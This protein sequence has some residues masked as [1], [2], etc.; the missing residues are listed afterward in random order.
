MMDKMTWLTRV[1]A[2][3]RPTIDNVGGVQMTRRS[4]VY[5]LTCAGLTCR[6]GRFNG[7]IIEKLFNAAPPKR[8]APLGRFHVLMDPTNLTF[9]YVR[10]LVSG[11]YIFVPIANLE[12]S[13]GLSWNATAMTN[14]FAHGESL[15]SSSGV[16][17]C[18]ARVACSRAIRMQLSNLTYD[19]KQSRRAE[20]SP[21]ARR[22]LISQSI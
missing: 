11:D 5:L 2:R 20:L 12:L 1:L 15:P 19:L 13:K 9:I 6:G 7:A 10:D 22:R 3:G 4:V 8:S 16:V 17:K 14:R 21:S 18:D